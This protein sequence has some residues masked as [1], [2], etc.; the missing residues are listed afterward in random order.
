M[1]TVLI[2][3]D[4]NAIRKLLHT[5]FDQGSGFDACVEAENGFEAI[6]ETKHLLPSLAVLDLSMP[7]MD[8]LQLAQE[9]KAIAPKLPIFMLTADYDA[10]I[11]KEA[12]SCGITAVFSKVDEMATLVANARA[13]CG[14]E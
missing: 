13:I 12:L 5:L 3:D 1:S 8:G 11:E 4:D 10:E 2:V 14:I 7:E 6:A 9:L